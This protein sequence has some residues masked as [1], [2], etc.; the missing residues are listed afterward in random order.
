VP[1][2]QIASLILLPVAGLVGGPTVNIDPASPAEQSLAAD[3][4]AT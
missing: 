2:K 3:A 4:A 1:A